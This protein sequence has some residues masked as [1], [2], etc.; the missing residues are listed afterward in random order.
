MDADTESSCQSS[1]LDL[2]QLYT[3]PSSTSLLCTLEQLKIEPAAWGAIGE[4]SQPDEAGLPRYLTGIVASPLA[5]IEDENVKEQIWEAASAR[6]SE[7]SGRSGHKTWLASYLLAKRLQSLVPHLP[8]LK[9]SGKVIELGAGTGLVGLV[10][11][12]M[13]DVHVHL[14]DLPVIVPNLHANANMNA[15]SITKGSTSV[16]ALDWSDVSSYHVDDH[17]SYGIVVAADPLY[18]PRHPAWLA[19]AINYILQQDVTARVVIE[20]PLREAYVPEIDELKSRL[21]ALG[22]VVLV[23]G[24][25][26]AFEDWQGGHQGNERTEVE[27]WWAVWQWAPLTSF[28]RRDNAITN[29]Q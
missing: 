14:T 5:W 13:F 9:S 2:P 11:A 27:C 20:L 3:R 29:P 19:A 23:E 10:V 18:S 28:P 16:G 8:S 4:I 1:F 24:V 7:R 12:A 25:E 26:R 6:L 15:A 17:R 21:V 22:L